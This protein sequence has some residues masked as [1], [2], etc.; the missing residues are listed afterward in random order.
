MIGF[1]FAL[2]GVKLREKVNLIYF[3]IMFLLRRFNVAYSL[4][5]MGRFQLCPYAFSS[6]P[7]RRIDLATNAHEWR[8]NRLAFVAAHLNDAVD[9]V[10]LKRMDMLLIVFVARF[11]VRQYV[12]KAN[13]IPD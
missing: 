8:K 12:F 11:F 7:D 5:E 6:H 13:I 3:I 9:N 2:C 4:F 1:A 10:E